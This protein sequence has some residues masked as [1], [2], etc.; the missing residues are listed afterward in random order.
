MCVYDGILHF[1][2]ASQLT[3]DKQTLEAKQESECSCHLHASVA[4]PVHVCVW[5]LACQGYTGLVCV[6]YIQDQQE[7]GILVAEPACVMVYCVDKR[8]V[9]ETQRSLAL[10]QA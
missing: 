10:C 8:C 1:S 3:V 7:P 5:S 4:M 6:L 2:V 9:K